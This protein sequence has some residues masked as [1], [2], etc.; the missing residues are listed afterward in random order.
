MNNLIHKLFH[1]RNSR[2]SVSASQRRYWFTLSSPAKVGSVNPNST[3]FT[4]I[5]LLVASTILVSALGAPLYLGVKGIILATEAGDKITATYL[6]EE[7]IELVRNQ[8]DTNILNIIAPGT[9]DPK[10]DDFKTKTNPG[11][12]CN[13]DGN[14]N[15]N[16]VVGRNLSDLNNQEIYFDL[17]TS[18][19]C[20]TLF[21]ST[22]EPR[23]YGYNGVVPSSFTRTIKIIYV[24]VSKKNEIYVTSKVEWTSRGT[25]KNVTV[26]DHLFS[27]GY[28]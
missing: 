24:D 7:G 17:C 22:T 10:W 8:R 20:P 19:P 4:L 28:D 6:A 15:K 27:Y 1:K 9:P 25:T 18:S 21:Q 16:C 11:V 3:G 12:L 13:F 23:I 26:E 5:E 2:G 14:G